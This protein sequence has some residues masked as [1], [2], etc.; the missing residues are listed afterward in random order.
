[1]NLQLHKITEAAL[2]VIFAQ[3][4][5]V[6]SSWHRFRFTAEALPSE[7]REGSVR[8][9]I[10]FTLVN[11]TTPRPPTCLGPADETAPARSVMPRFRLC[12]VACE[13]L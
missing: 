11:Q 3:S 10:A 12:H 13:A 4:A 6:W 5:L 8:P 7:D 9:S 1:M 2:P